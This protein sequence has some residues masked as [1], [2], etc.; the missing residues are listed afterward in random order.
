MCLCAIPALLR[1]SMHHLYAASAARCC[2]AIVS[3]SAMSSL[4]QLEKTTRICALYITYTSG[5]LSLSTLMY[6]VC[7]PKCIV[8]GIFAI[9]C[10]SARRPAHPVSIRS[11]LRSPY[12]LGNVV[13]RCGAAPTYFH[14]A[15]RLRRMRPLRSALPLHTSMQTSKMRQ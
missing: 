13:G 12:A 15:R 11:R 8:S 9:R 5:N 3:S 7:R 4:C 10:G 2:Q 14:D 1:V 6:N